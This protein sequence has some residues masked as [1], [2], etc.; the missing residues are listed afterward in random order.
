MKFEPGPG[1]GGHW[2]PIDPF[3]LT[4]KVRQYGVTTR[5]IELAG[6]INTAMPAWV[7]QKLADA[8]NERG[9]SLKGSRI[10]VLGVAYTWTTSGRA[11]RSRSWRSCARRGPLSRTTIPTFPGCAPPA[12]TVST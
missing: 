2:I 1:L 3:Y 7:V 5:F 10:L 4:W 8:L 11:R 6:E 12:G 9:K